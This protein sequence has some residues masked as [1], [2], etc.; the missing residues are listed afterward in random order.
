MSV[1]RSTGLLAAFLIV[2]FGGGRAAADGTLTTV[3]GGGKY[4]DGGPV[5]RASLAGM[6]AIA[7]DAEENLYVLDLNY[8]LIRRVDARTHEITA[9]VGSGLKGFSGDGGPATEARVN[10]PTGFALDRDGNIYFT[11]SFNGVIRVVNR[12]AHPIV[13]AG[14]ISVAA[15]AIETI[16][17]PGPSNETVNFT[18][19]TYGGCLSAPD[20]FGDGGPATGA[21]FFFIIG[22]ALRE[23]DDGAPPDVYVCDSEQACVRRI[24]GATGIIT[25]YAGNRCFSIPPTLPTTLPPAPTGDGGP[26]VNAFMNNPLRAAFDT[27]GNLFVLTQSDARIRRVDAVTGFVSTVAGTG[28]AGYSGDGGKA[29]AAQIDPRA[30]ISGALAFD[31]G[32]N[33]FFSDTNNAVIRRIEA[34]DGEIGLDSN[35]SKVAGT[36]MNDPFY[37]GEYSSAQDGARATRADLDRPIGIAFRKSE[38]FFVEPTSCM[39]RRL[40]PGPAGLIHGDP[41]ERIFDVAGNAGL[42]QPFGLA[43]DRDGTIFVADQFHSRI[44]RVARDGTMTVLIGTNVPSY[45]QGGT[46]PEPGDGGPISKA[47]VGEPQD[48]RITHEGNLY[49]LDYYVNTGSTALR[50][51]T[52]RRGPE[53]EA[54]IVAGSRID[55]IVSFPFYA[56]GLAVGEGTA[57]VS[58]FLGNQVWAV[59][60]ADGSMRLVAGN[61]HATAGTVVTN[62]D[63]GSVI[64]TPAEKGDKGDPTMATLSLPLSLA[65]DDEGRRLFISDVGNRC[66]RVVDFREST[67]DTLIEFTDSTCQV[68]NDLFVRGSTIYLAQAPW[69]SNFN[70]IAFDFTA[71]APAPVVIAGIP[72]DRNDHT[73][74]FTGDGPATMV[75]LGGSGAIT[76]DEDGVLYLT[77]GQSQRVRRLD[78]GVATSGGGEDGPAPGRRS[79]PLR[80]GAGERPPARGDR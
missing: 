18:P 16:A 15:G 6:V 71:P 59:S 4:G 51:I 65:L 53:R 79:G 46:E 34:K 27:Q 66:V 8:E 75:N 62:D 63:C 29:I 56:P 80:H 14:S 55:R 67:I 12:Q 49:F 32:G 11:D 13:V 52:A 26:A 42:K 61:G 41:R 44:H 3:A 7:F 21:T 47:T 31:A 17:G 69:Y 48:L 10:W 73:G 58:D 19:S 78:L 20:N 38:L 37:F 72:F 23:R 9:V 33:L 22:I 5:E 70:V 68:T 64:G 24:D 36:G 25:T 28:Y 35:I 74:G 54:R 40:V 50:R 60:L 30:F 1:S 45:S 76:L 77:E 39:I 2:A 43:V 57:Y